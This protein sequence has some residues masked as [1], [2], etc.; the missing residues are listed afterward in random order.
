MDVAILDQPGNGNRLPDPVVAL[1]PDMA[2][3]ANADSKDSDREE[4]AVGAVH[5]G[6]QRKYS[7]PPGIEDVREAYEDLRTIL[8]PNRKIGPGF[9]PITQERLEGVRQFLWNYVDPDTIAHGGTV[10]SSWKAASEQT[11][12]ALGKG[13]YLAWNLQKWARAFIIDCKDL[14]SK[15]SV[16]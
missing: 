1:V 13:N 4:D 15:S 14:P 10:G 11:A 9:D 2:D 7:P 5:N 12:H 6:T 3:M 16:W 8:K